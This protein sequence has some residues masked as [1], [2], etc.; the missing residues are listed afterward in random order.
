M[1]VLLNLEGLVYA[2]EVDSDIYVERLCRLRSSLVIATIYGKLRVVSILHPATLVILVCLGVYALLDELLV[3]LLHQVELTR[4]V[5]HRTC[6]TALVNHKERRNTSLTCY[7]GIVSTKRRSDVYDTRTILYC[8]VVPRNHTERLVGSRVPV[9]L[10]VHLYGL[11][12]GDELLVVHTYQLGT[13]PATYNLKGDEFVTRLVI[14]QRDTLGLL[15]EVRVE[16]R[17]SQYG[18]NLLARVAVVCA[19]G[20][21]VN[22]RAYAERSI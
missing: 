21:V 4:Q 16:Q 22:L 20:H 18:G 8:N 2:L 6:L 5:N 9:A 12:P 13:L 14:L 15:V 7:E 3:Q 17:L 11:H 10:L 1:G 19:N